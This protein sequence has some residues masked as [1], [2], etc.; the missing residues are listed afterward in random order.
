MKES[1]EE[2]V[3]EK[4]LKTRVETM[5]NVTA[6]YKQYM[7]CLIK[8]RSEQKLDTDE[9]WRQ[10][11]L[12]QTDYMNFTSYS[13]DFDKGYADFVKKYTIA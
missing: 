13:S 12:L 11:R 9:Y 4:Q 1:E 8:A 3:F 6:L 2:L 7:R 10:V 5:D